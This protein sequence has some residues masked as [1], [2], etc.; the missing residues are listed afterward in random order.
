MERLLRC[1]ATEQYF[2]S[3]YQ[4]QRRI[5]LTMV[6]RS[7]RG[8]RIL[9]EELMGL[10][11]CV[12]SKAVLRYVLTIMACWLRGMLGMVGMAAHWRG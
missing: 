9:G 3:I 11:D 12:G 7:R 6:G 1:L 4:G 10:L 5:G 8:I 2:S